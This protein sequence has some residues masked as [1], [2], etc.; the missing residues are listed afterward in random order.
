MNLEAK[1]LGDC[2]PSPQPACHHS[3]GVH[4]QLPHATD[5]KHE[6]MCEGET[7]GF[8][9]PWGTRGF[10]GLFQST[11]NISGRR[12]GKETVFVKLSDRA[13]VLSYGAPHLPD[14]SCSST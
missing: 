6:E 5:I 11:G 14:T 7:L 1:R 3:E 13:G 2:F 10:L 12:E 9:I 4:T 8:K